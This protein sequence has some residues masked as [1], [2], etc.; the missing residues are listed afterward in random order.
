MYIYY[1]ADTEIN[2]VFEFLFFIIE[3]KKG[4][5]PYPSLFS[6]LKNDNKL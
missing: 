6:L 3:V 2:L 1:S 5:F 4:F